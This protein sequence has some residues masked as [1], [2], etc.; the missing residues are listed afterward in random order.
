MT[1]DRNPEQRVM[2]TLRMTDYARSKQFYVDALGFQVDWEHRFEPGFPVFA[3]VSRDGMAFF[4]T[5]HTGDGSVGGLVRDVLADLGD[6]GREPGVTGVVREHLRDQRVR[7]LERGLPAAA[8]LARLEMAA[9]QLERHTGQRVVEP[10]R[11][12]RHREV[13]HAASSAAGSGP[14]S[15]VR[16]AC[17]RCI[18]EPGGSSSS[19]R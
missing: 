10:A 16:S 3:Q 6:G 7:P 2:P 19:A 14:S 1:A 13:G 18:T 9:H 15:C 17:S 12:L 4:L 8:S 5:E 11:V